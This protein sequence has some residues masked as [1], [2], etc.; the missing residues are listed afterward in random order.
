MI[1]GNTLPQDVE[2]TQLLGNNYFNYF[3]HNISKHTS[4]ES[5][6]VPHWI[7]FNV[8]KLS[9]GWAVNSHDPTLYTPARYQVAHN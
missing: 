3:S 8:N 7:W 5:E 1:S 4:S 2:E 6:S 9:V